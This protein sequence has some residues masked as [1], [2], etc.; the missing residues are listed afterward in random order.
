MKKV[1][2]TCKGKLQ[3]EINI[4]FCGYNFFKT[5]KKKQIPLDIMKK[6]TN[7][8]CENKEFGSK[9]TFHKNNVNQNGVI[10]MT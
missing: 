5:R 1:S 9:N 4:L 7:N 8:K 2:Y 6:V 3:T 10:C